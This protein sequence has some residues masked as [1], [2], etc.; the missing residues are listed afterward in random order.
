MLTV[1]MARGAVK[2]QWLT[3]GGNRQYLTGPTEGVL[4][5]TTNATPPSALT[6]DGNEMTPTTGEVFRTDAPNGSNTSWRLLRGGTEYGHIFNQSA[7]NHFQLDAGAGDL[8]FLT[9]GTVRARLSGTLTGQTVNNYPGLDLSGL[10]GVGAFTNF[11]IPYPFSMLHL[12]DGGTQEDGYRDWMYA[13]TTITSGSDLCYFGMKFGPNNDQHAATVAW[14]D[15]DDGPDGP[16]LMQFIFVR[17]NIGASAAAS[18][19]GLQAAEFYPPD[20]DHVNFGV[21]NFFSAGSHPTERVHL[22]DGRLRIEQ[23]PDDPAAVDSFYVMVVDRTVATTTNQ[24]RGVVKWVDPSNLGSGDCKWTLQGP[25]GSNSNVSTAYAGNTGCPQDDRAVGV[26]IQHP[27]AKL[28]VYTEKPQL[29][30]GLGTYSDLRNDMYG[31]TAMYGLARAVFTT[32]FNP[33]SMRGV[34]GVAENAKYSYGVVG[35]AGISCESEDAHA[36]AVIGVLGQARACDNADIAIG[37]HGKA[38]GAING[39]DWAAYFDGFGFINAPFWVYSD[40]QLKQN[41]EDLPGT[42]A[43]ES[44]MALQPKSYEFVTD[45]FGSLA[46][47]EGPQRGFISQEVENVLPDLVKTVRRPPVIDSAGTEVEAAMEFKAMNYEGLIPL[48]VSAI[49]YQN[50]RIEQLGALLSECCAADGEG[51]ALPAN[52]GS[53]GTTTALETDLRIIPNPVADRTEL[54]YAVGTEGAVRLTITA[55]DG[56]TILVQNEGTRATGTYSYGW[57]TTS[58]APGTYH[59]TLYVNDELV[60]RKAVKVARR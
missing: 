15:N 28:H 8:R 35:N 21:G 19:D 48:L 45:Q 3:G 30:S 38:G 57:D 26:G 37:V 41:V 47:P 56:R 43:M 58:L 51:R 5:G 32:T 7:D 44:L 22:L 55:S 10:L 52:Q 33:G 16:D 36:A 53:A 49:Q 46:L 2:A 9:S 4:I 13:G 34:Q 31:A 12:D 27:K 23:L 40:S 25:P 54:R 59:C 11:N 24:E 18:D 42:Q 6:V 50:T 60:V 29:F 17:D 20:D 39:Q 14:S 1:V